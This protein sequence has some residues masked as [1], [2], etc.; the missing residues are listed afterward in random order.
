[1]QYPGAYA[2]LTREQPT[3][4]NSVASRTGSRMRFWPWSAAAWQGDST[5][6]RFQTAEEV[7]V[8]IL[9]PTLPRPCLGPPYAS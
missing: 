3:R 6:E 1:M 9:A 5:T 2:P 4:S 8:L 7:T